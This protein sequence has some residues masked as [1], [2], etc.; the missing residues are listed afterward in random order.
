MATG[1]LGLNAGTRPHET[2]TKKKLMAQDR[3]VH[4]TQST[5][6]RLPYAPH[7]T[8]PNGM[9]KEWQSFLMP[10]PKDATRCPQKPS[11][12]LK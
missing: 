3:L 9:P 2:H 10:E 12:P 6:S 7:G 8:R 11:Q 1:H 5:G 4:P